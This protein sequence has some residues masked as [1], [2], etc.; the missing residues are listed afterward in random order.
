M[1]TLFLSFISP[2]GGGAAERSHRVTRQRLWFNTSGGVA[3]PLSITRHIAANAD[4][5]AD[6]NANSAA[7]AAA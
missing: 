2:G 4:A 6:G 7:A 3:R 1:F 5:D